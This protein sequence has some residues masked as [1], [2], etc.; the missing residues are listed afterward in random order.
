M[1]IGVSIQSTATYIK[2]YLLLVENWYRNW[3]QGHDDPAYEINVLFPS[4]LL[5]LTCR[6]S[7]YSVFPF[8]GSPITQFTCKRGFGTILR[9]NRQRPIFWCHLLFSEN[10]IN[11]AITTSLKSVV[12]HSRQQFLKTGGMK[13]GDLLRPVGSPSESGHFFIQRLKDT[14]SNR[15]IFGSIWTLVL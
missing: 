9:K 1:R 3:E 5:I 7:P 14:P 10:Q 8:D 11:G 2:S 4:L 12:S 13:Q 15:K 6:N